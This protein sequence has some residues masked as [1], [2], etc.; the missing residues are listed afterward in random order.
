MSEQDNLDVIRRG[1]EAFGRGDLDAL[2]RLFDNDIEWVTPGPADMPIAGRRRG[3]Q[4]VAQFFR[5]LG[6][7]F[8]IQRFEPKEFIAKDDRVVVL[9]EDTAQ[10]RNTETTVDYAWVHVFKLKDG[11]IASFCEYG[12]M[13]AVVAALRAA[14][15]AT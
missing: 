4:E 13:T 5:I 3:V 2:L 10:I 11:R 9:G 14:Q 6:E 1:Y 8:D 12:D 15:T 7:T